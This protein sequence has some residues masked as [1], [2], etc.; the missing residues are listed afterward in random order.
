[1]EFLITESQLRALLT[2]EEKSMLGT[3]M[4]RLNSFTKQIVNRSFKSYGLN[5]RMLLTW[6]TAVGGMVLPLDQFLRDQNFN[7]TE[8]QRMLVLAG[9]AFSLFF[10]TKRPFIQLFSVIKEEGLED[11]FKVGLRK[12]TQ[13]KNAF[14]NF[15]SSVGAGSAGFLDTIA[16]SF[17]IPIITDIQSVL[18]ETQDIDEA[19]IL[20]AERLFASGIVLMSSQVLTETVKKVLEKLK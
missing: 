6:G 19:A 16:Y 8:D 3:Y 1:M 13:L 18:M 7:L 17:M 9:L 11:I 15:M 2:E 14:L 20:I 5:L 4:K 10:E 12:G